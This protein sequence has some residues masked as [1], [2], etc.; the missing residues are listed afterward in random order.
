MREISP[1]ILQR[2][3]PAAA[4]ETAMHNPPV[5]EIEEGLDLREYWRIVKKHLWLIAV[6]C[7][8]AILVTAL[9]VLSMTPIYTAETTVLIERKGPQVLNIPEAVTESL[10]PDEYDY[11]RTQY[12]ILKSRALAL[13]VIKEQELEKNPV[14]VEQGKESGLIA[15]LWKKGRKR[16]RQL[17]S[18]SSPSTPVQ[19]S[20]QSDPPQQAQ[21]APNSE[22]NLGEIYASM[23]EVTPVQRTRLVKI[24]FSSPDPALAASVANAH[25]L[26]Y[27]RQGVRI[28]TSANEEAQNF[29]Q[30]KLVE[31]RER[32]EQSETTLNNYRR[33]QGIIS[34]DDKENIVVDRLSDL[35]K[36][37]TEAEAERI[38]FEAQVHAIRKKDYDSLPAVISSSLIQ[39]LKEETSRLEGEYAKLSA[40]FKPGYPR[41][42]ELRAQVEENRRRLQQEIQRVVGG[43]E[44]GYRVAAGKEKQLRTKMDEQKAATLGLKDA[45][46]QYAILARDV[47][48]NRQLYDSVLQRM[49]EMG[50]AAEIRSSNVSVVDQA[51]PPSSPSRPNKMFSLF[52]SSIIGLI[53][54]VGLA[55][56]FERWD[57]TLKTPEEV[58]R[59][60]RLPNLTV[61]PDF[62]KLNGNTYGY[63]SKSR[64]QSL[65]NKRANGKNRGYVPAVQAGNPAKE[66][67][68]A[69]HPMS[70]VSESYRALRTAILLSRA[71]EPPQVLLFTSGTHG[72]GK[73]ATTLN[74]AVIFAQMGVKVLIIDGD[75]RRPRCHKVLGVANGFGLSEVL[76]G[77]RELQE[78]L[79]QTAIQNVSFLSSGAL[80]P[81]PA[82]LLGSRK[83]AETL[84]TLREW[85]DYI[86]IDSPPVMPVSDAI[87][88]STMVD[89]VVLVVGGQATPKDIVRE[90]RA[91]LG[92]ARAKIL[93]VVLNRVDVQSGDYS[94]YY[95][96]YYSYYHHTHTEAGGQ[97]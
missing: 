77:Q 59:Y 31:L 83:M 4:E 79:T 12:E 88:L 47:D 64:Q 9:I 87:L 89:G 76:T 71:G 37:L 38:T 11:Y 3:S 13:R 16:V 18:S 90:T 14:F 66:L 22:L 60:L 33:S 20:E 92:Y 7:F 69:H 36:R 19:A 54:G 23:L 70:V 50:V 34:L 57:N 58:E 65:N 17:F 2:V 96:H 1:Y 94:Y 27:I 28:R 25:A 6:C 49:K 52:L 81:N 63:G 30:E 68:I 80:P 74:T 10:F 42:A 48:T 67:V 21:S 72:E 26:T 8:A 95:H 46:V 86:L 53:G 32:V 78:V 43:I 29:L 84:G 75:L 55:F 62:L 44:S 82:E 51:E 35:N 15:T 41:V 91:R 85:Y 24:A 39:S 40:Q 61:V 73:T 93:G 97:D 5:V 45:S 56:F